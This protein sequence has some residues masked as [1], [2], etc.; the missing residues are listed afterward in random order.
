MC[1][2]LVPSSVLFVIIAFHAN[3]DHF[4]HFIG[5]AFLPVAIMNA[6]ALSLGY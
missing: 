3:Y 4:L 2:F 6:L 1:R 5:E